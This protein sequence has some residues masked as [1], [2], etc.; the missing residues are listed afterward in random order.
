MNKNKIYDYLNSLNIWY[1]V[2]KHSAIFNMAEI[3]NVDLP[4][5]EADAKNLFVHDDKKG[6][7]I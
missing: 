6:I 5:S 7:I 4:Y 3:F 2:K 1:E